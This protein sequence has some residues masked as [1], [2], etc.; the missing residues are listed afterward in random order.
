MFLA[1]KRIHEEAFLPTKAH[2]DDCGLDLYSVEECTVS[3]GSKQVTPVSTGIC[4]EVPAG[5]GGFILPR[6]G[7]ATRGVTV[8]NS[9]VLI[10]PGYTGE[11][12]V[13]LINH[14]V[15]DLKIKEGDR[16]G[17]LL[18]IKVESVVPIEVYSLLE[19]ARG[20]SGFGS[21]GD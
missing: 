6:S 5:H 15:T 14:G 17:Q 12:K 1:V 11:I 13:L 20:N 19:S 21:S 10:D 3:A 2:E 7:L 16:I 8:A 18:I 9:P 4:V